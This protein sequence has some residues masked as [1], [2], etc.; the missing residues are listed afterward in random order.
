MLDVPVERA[1]LSVR[2]VNCLKVLGIKTMAEAAEATDAELFS[3]P[4][5]GRMTLLEVREAIFQRG[6]PMPS[7]Y[8]RKIGA[9]ARKA[10][11]AAV[12]AVPMA[13]GM[14]LR[15]WFAGQALHGLL[16]NPKS[17]ATVVDFAESA[18]RMADGMIA[19]RSGQ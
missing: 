4:N 15:D 18:Y 16:S 10:K 7:E 14:T 9:S 12:A 1:G 2:A 6:G 11:P 5:F 17:R 8:V 19:A 13:Q 3:A